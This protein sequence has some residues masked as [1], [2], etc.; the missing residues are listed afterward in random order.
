MKAGASK[1]DIT[2]KIGVWLD[3]I[4]RNK[5]SDSILS[6]LYARALYI[7][8]GMTEIVMVVC[9]VIA[10]DEKD[11]DTIKDTIEKQTGIPTDNIVIA[12][13]HTHS[14]PST[15][16][17]LAP[18]ETEYVKELPP[19]IS[20]SVKEAKESAINCKIKVTYGYEP[21]ISEYRRLKD[22]NGKIWMNW[23]EYDKNSIVG[24]A[25]PDDPEVGIISITDEEG[26]TIAIIFN[27]TGHPNTLTGFDY[28]ITSDYPGEACRLLEQ[29]LGGTAIFFNGAQGSSDIPGFNDRNPEGIKKRGKI[30][31]Q[32]VID[33]LNENKEPHVFTN[34]L[35]I[36][37]VKTKIPRRE[38]S[39]E[40][41]ERAKAI[42]NR[43]TKKEKSLRD[44]V[45]EDIYAKWLLDMLAENK[46][47]YLLP[48]TGIR[49]GDAYIFAEPGELFTEIGLR[50]KKYSPFTYTFIMGLADGYFGYIPTA[51]AIQEGG[52]ATRTGLHSK[53]DNHA[54]DYI[55]DTAI[56]LGEE[57]L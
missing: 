15:L 32:A 25:G 12:S 47:Y 3:G 22:K 29:E 36:L 21:T 52:Y 8:N 14:G 6:S 48:F 45:D 20:Q 1:T 9:D 33:T 54:E 37:K 34:K 53:L 35:G 31:Y 23:E 13:T 30:L 27:H 24:P 11:V 51:R 10:L 42:V 18:K 40:E 50:I 17:I 2:P 7:T 57:L 38:V 16:G 28:A 56:R 5:P 39:Q 41:I 44:G 19:K 46:D 43:T 4:P 26:K 55:I 49:I